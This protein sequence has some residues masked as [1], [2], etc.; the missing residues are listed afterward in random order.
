[1]T[2]EALAAAEAHALRSGDQRPVIHTLVNLLDQDRLS[3]N[4]KGQ[5]EPARHAHALARATFGDR[6]TDLAL[7]ARRCHAMAQV[8]GRRRGGWAGPNWRD[9]LAQRLRLAGEFHPSVSNFY[10]CIGVGS[11]SVGDVAG[12]M[13]AFAECCGSRLPA[14][15]AGPPTRS[16]MPNTTWAFHSL[17]HDATTRPLLNCG[18]ATPPTRRCRSAPG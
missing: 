12:S 4:L 17:P 13:I 11:E 18:R 14:A 7:E 2:K 15:M 9:I 3:M 8:R 1:M 16:P 10:V 6:P 5:L